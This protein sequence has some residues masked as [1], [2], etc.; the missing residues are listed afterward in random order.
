MKYIDAEKLKTEIKRLEEMD[1]S[2]DTFEQS[3]G[4]YE[5]LDRIKSF[6]VSLQQEPQE[7]ICSKCIHYGKDD[8][9]CYNPHG[10]MQSWINEN[11]I[12]KCTGFCEKE[13]EKQEMDLKKEIDK[14]VSECTN[15]YNF[16]WDKFARHFY[17]LGRNAKKQ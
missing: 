17:E 13:Q 9:Y 7:E 6:I 15:G 16:D 5:A 11:G 10:G 1:Y 12:Y 8:G 3:V 14:T 4:F 2:C